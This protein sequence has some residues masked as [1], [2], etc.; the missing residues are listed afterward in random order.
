MEWQP[1]ETAQKNGEPILLYSSADFSDGAMGWCPTLNVVVGWWDANEWS[2]QG[3][4]WKS[5][6]LEEGA[7]DSYGY[8]SPTSMAIH[9][10]HW[11]PLP[12]DP[13]ALSQDAKTTER[14]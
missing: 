6:L 13:A 4:Y 3:G 5:A 2:R 7:A 9:P 14:G 8:T 12:P 1:I 10:T 11:M